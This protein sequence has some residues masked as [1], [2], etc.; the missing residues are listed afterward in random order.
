MA[1]NRKLL[2]RFILKKKKKFEK[3]EDKRT[4]ITTQPRGRLRHGALADLSKATQL[5][6]LQKRFYGVLASLLQKPSAIFFCLFS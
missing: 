4:S 2:P 1:P 6:R 3:L 5:S